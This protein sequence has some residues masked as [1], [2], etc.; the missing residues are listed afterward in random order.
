MLGPMSEDERLDLVAAAAEAHAGLKEI[1]FRLRWQLGPKAPVLKAALKVEQ[2][3][4]R[5]ERELQRL[6]LTDPEPARRRE[7]LPDV[8]R[9]GKVIDIERLRR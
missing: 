5:L 9:G 6:D 7:P 2:E 8:R 1:A 4:F 3:A